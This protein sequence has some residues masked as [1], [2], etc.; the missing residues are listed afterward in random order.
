MI[1]LELVTGFDDVFFNMELLFMRK[2]EI[3]DL[4]VLIN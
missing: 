2:I 4:S 3:K 1:F